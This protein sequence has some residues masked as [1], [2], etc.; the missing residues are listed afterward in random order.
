[1]KQK[2]DEYVRSYNIG[3]SDYAKHKIQP[4]DIW[5]AYKLNPFLA[6]MVK[7]LLRTKSE[8]GLSPLEARKLD[9]KKIK[10]IALECK[11]QQLNGIVWL[12]VPTGDNV[13][14]I[15]IVDIVREYEMDNLDALMLTTILS[16]NPNYDTIILV[17]DRRMEEITNQMNKGGK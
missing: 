11:R 9:Y 2:E 12:T 16:N 4:W 3:S 13:P 8:N 10:H 14:D 7:R 17:C 1:M 5:I 6:D 15:P